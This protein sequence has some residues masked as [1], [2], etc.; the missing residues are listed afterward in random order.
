MHRKRSS[1]IH[2]YF[3]D[4]RSAGLLQ[5]LGR[6]ASAFSAFFSS[7]LLSAPEGRLRTFSRAFFLRKLRGDIQEIWF[8]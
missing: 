4:C 2:F 1:E 8:A 7:S 5:S 3:G 6:I